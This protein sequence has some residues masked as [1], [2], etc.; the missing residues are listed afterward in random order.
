MNGIKNA[1]KMSFLDK[2]DVKWSTNLRFE[3]DRKRMRLVGG[4]KTFC[5]ANCVKRGESIVLELIVEA[6]SFVLKF[7]SNVIMQEIK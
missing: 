4:W 6:E 5:N 2:D 7:Y 3:K 1:K